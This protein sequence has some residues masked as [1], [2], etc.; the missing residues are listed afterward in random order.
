MLFTDGQMN[1]LRERWRGAGLIDTDSAWEWLPRSSSG[2]ANTGGT[3]ALQDYRAT[4]ELRAHCTARGFNYLLNT[5]GYPLPSMFAT[6]SA[7]HCNKYPQVAS[8]YRQLCAHKQVSF[9]RSTGASL[10]TE[11]AEEYDAEVAMRFRQLQKEEEMA[12]LQDEV[13][14]AVDTVDSSALAGVIQW[15]RA[16]TSTTHPPPPSPPP[17]RLLAWLPPSTT[18]TID[19]ISSS[20][21]TNHTVPDYSFCS[22]DK[23]EQERPQL[24]DAATGDDMD[25][26]EEHMVGVRSSTL[27]AVHDTKAGGV[28]RQSLLHFSDSS[29]RLNHKWL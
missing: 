27:N 9:D 12:V 19:P 26:V 6:R 16:V 10:E 22:D 17:E 21:H 3:W 28:E 25:H 14:R 8:L 4:I 1:S 18:S 7:A 5:L 20:G 2:T 11:L 13:T 24:E 15:G 23:E 29:H